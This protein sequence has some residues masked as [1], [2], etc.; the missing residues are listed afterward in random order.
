MHN[1]TKFQG[2]PSIPTKNL[3]T[4]CG[5][6][7]ARAA[8]QQQLLQ[9]FPG[10]DDTFWLCAIDAGAAANAVSTAASAAGAAADAV[11]NAADA[12]AA[13]VKKP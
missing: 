8:H 5:Y 10:L 1:L 13:A 9:Y 6:R 7:E 2:K 3:Q 11:K 4:Q 12:A